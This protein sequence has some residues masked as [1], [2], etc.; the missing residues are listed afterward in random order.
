MSDRFALVALLIAML[1]GVGPRVE[2]AAAGL[3]QGY[4][5]T[6]PCEDLKLKP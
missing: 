4:A 5:Y 1:W 6:G 2:H 3:I